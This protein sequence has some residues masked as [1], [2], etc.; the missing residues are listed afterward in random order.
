MSP[1][2]R[3]DQ[4]QYLMIWIL[5]LNS[6]WTDLGTWITKNLIMI[7]TRNE[8][9]WI[10]KHCFFKVIKYILLR[11]MM[12]AYIFGQEQNESS[13]GGLHNH[14]HLHSWLE[15]IFLQQLSSI[16]ESRIRNCRHYRWPGRIRGSSDCSFQPV[17][18]CGSVE[19]ISLRRGA[20]WKGP[21]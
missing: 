8:I 2:L 6:K 21:K 16:L 4:Y 19:E 17:V 5:L 13:S 3:H 1:Q 7:F 12:L 14:N 10:E 18:I 15:R 9:L 20:G 11:I